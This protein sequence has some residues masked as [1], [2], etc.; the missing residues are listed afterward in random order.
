MAGD[1]ELLYNIGL[2]NVNL[3]LPSTL[4]RACI[5]FIYL[6]DHSKCVC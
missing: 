1:V 5:V 4:Y 2:P 3:N 6:I